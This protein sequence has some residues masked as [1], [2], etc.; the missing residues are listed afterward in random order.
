LRSSWR[1]REGSI[2]ARA[3]VSNVGA[4]NVLRTTGVWQ[5]GDG[6]VPGRHQGAVA[7]LI[8]YRLS[9]GLVVAGGG[10]TGVGRRSHLSGVAR[11]QGWQGLAATAAGVF[12]VLG[13]GGAHHG[14]RGVRARG[15]WI[16]RYISI[17][18]IAGAAALAIVDR[19]R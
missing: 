7:V 2:C 3:A 4:S 14:E 18:S 17:G 10:W 11:V 8:A 13:A 16:T 19:H 9:N 6:D 5:R 15:F 1:E 12:A